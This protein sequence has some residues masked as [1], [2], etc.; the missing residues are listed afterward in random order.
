MTGNTEKRPD[1]SYAQ[2]GAT[3][4]ILI[5]KLQDAGA[6]NVLDLQGSAQSLCCGKGGLQELRKALRP[7][8]VVRRF[9]FHTFKKSR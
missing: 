7:I 2:Y 6:S 9:Q 3:V 4:D 1:S 8:V 5:E